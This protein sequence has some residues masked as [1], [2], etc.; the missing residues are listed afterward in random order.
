MLIE[1]I[2]DNDSFIVNP[3]QKSIRLKVDIGLALY[4]FEEIETQ[5]YP[6]LIK[7]HFKKALDKYKKLAAFV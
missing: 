7:Y 6:T 3:G 4:Y 2:I 5:S 1:I